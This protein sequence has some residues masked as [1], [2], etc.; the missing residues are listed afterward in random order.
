[1]SKISKEELEAFWR[2]DKDTYQRMYAQRMQQKA[3]EVERQGKRVT[4]VPNDGSGTL[5]EVTITAPRETEEQKQARLKQDYE[6]VADNAITVAGFIP[7]VDT[8][9][10]IA[11][12]GNSLRKGNY[13]AALFGIGA[14]VIPGI[15]APILRKSAQ[16][17]GNFFSDSF[18]KIKDYRAAHRI[19]SIMNNNIKD[20]IQVGQHYHGTPSLK[21]YGS[22][23]TYEDGPLQLG[24]T[25]SG[26]KQISIPTGNYHWREDITNINNPKLLDVKPDKHYIKNQTPSVVKEVINSNDILQQTGIV[27]I[28]NNLLQN[29]EKITINPTDRLTKVGQRMDLSLSPSRVVQFKHKPRL[30]DNKGRLVSSSASRYFAVPTKIEHQYTLWHKSGGKL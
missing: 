17:L 16:K 15:S 24:Y 29:V 1:M 14:A 9:A 18:S 26:I 3:D 7:G 6:N 20:G 12:I 8:F 5:P 11:D 27:P 30:I 13:N 23:T 19:S 4:Y 22:Y 25:T 21:H 28:Y 2:G 10:D